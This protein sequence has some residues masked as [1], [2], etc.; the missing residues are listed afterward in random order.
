MLKRFFSLKNKT[1]SC[2]SSILIVEGRLRGR[3]FIQKIFKNRHDFLFLEN[4]EKAYQY[5]L[6]NT[7]DL[8]ILSAHLKGS[9]TVDLCINL[10]NDTKTR[11]IPILVIADNGANMVEYYLQKVEGY[12][13]KPFKAGELMKNVE[14]LL[15]IGGE[16][17]KRSDHSKNVNKL[18][19][20]HHLGSG[21]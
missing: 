10:K 3:E 4:K 11:D 20:V 5:A 16:K 17:H 19:H 6:N 21:V 13:I 15:K 2:T 12:L 9:K 18:K 8:I 14:N 1:V 7:V